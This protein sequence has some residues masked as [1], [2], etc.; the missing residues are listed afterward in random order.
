[1]RPSWSL[2]AFAVVAVLGAAGVAVAQ[3]PSAQT[4]ENCRTQA[5]SQNLAGEARVNAITQC[6]VSGTADPNAGM[7]QAMYEACRNDAIARNLAGEARARAINECVSLATIEPAA[8][9]TPYSYDS[10]R[11]AAIAKGVRGDAFGQF[12]NRCTKGQ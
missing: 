1:M 4:Y 9:S 3:A 2:A 10:C 6:M 11:A 5:I 12:I 8:G 7:K